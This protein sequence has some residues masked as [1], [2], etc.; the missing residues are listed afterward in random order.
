MESFVISATDERIEFLKKKDKRLGKVIDEI[1][2]IECTVHSDPFEFIVSQIVGQMLSN[3][4]AHIIFNRLKLLCED[5]ICTTKLLNLGREELKQIV[6]SNSK[7][8][9]IKCL[10]LAV[11]EKTICLEELL[12][13]TMKR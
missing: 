1:G 10:S 8:E 6:L 5:D 3:K 11:Q 7:C 9:Y 2:P 4:V 13:K 12:K